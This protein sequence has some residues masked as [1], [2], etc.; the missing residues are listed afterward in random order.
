M[1]FELIKESVIQSLLEPW[2]GVG[3][4]GTVLQ[5][6]VVQSDEVATLIEV[7]SFAPNWW[8]VIIPAV[9][10]S[11]LVLARAF[12]L[13]RSHII[14]QN[15]EQDRHERDMKLADYDLSKIRE[16]GAIREKI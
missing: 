8:S 14:E 12:V 9:A 5:A 16:N 11:M 4:I 3:V 13:V 1:N 2:T 7:G 15:R 10:T 6:V